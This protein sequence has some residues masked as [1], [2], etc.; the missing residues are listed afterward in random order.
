MSLP[1]LSIDSTP[2]RVI[3]HVARVRVDGIRLDQY[4]HGVFAEFSRSGVQRVIDAGGVEV[5]GRV[6]KASYKVRHGDLIR[7]TPPA[8]THGAP[9]AEDIPLEVLYQDEFLAVVNKP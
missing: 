1:D 6:A 5:N 7:I 2:P 9:A 4:L 3:D 8:P